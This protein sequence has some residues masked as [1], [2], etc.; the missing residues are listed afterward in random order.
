MKFIIHCLKIFEQYFANLPQSTKMSESYHYINTKQVE[1]IAGGDTDFLKEL[2]DIFLEQIPD[3][4]Q[5]IRVSFETENWPV[6][7]REAHTAKS[8][9]MTFGMEDTGVLLKKI[10]LDCEQNQ[11]ENIPEMVNQV[12]E[13]LEAAVPELQSLKNSL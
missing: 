3:F 9:A 11:L 2:V 10:Q 12:T 8:S 4:V 6:L 7:A 1:E 5:K 13:Q